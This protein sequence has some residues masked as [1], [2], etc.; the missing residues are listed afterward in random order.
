M[1]CTLAN[2]RPYTLT[3]ALSRLID[4]QTMS[5]KKT[6]H[7]HILAPMVYTLGQ[8]ENRFPVL[9]EWVGGGREDPE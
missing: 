2:F 8:A 4:A 3:D 6:M 9:W 1:F 5:Q 7:R